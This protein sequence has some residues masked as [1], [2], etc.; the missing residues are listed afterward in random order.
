MSDFS[1]LRAQGAT[2][3]ISWMKESPTTSRLA[4]V[5]ERCNWQVPEVDEIIRWII[6]QPN[7]T[8]EIILKLLDMSGFWNP[9]DFEDLRIDDPGFYGLCSEMLEG[10][11]AR[12]YAWALPQRVPL[13]P[14]PFEIKNPAWQ[15]IP[16]VDLIPVYEDIDELTETL[17]HDADIV[18]GLLGSGFRDDAAARAILL[19]SAD[20]SPR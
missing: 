17:P 3:L 18:L 20:D 5:A 9:D 6:D 10:L 19:G 14:F 13:K 16:E 15:G 1:D 8:A 4:S 12:R 11:R 2:F 7:C